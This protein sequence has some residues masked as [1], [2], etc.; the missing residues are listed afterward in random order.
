MN[1]VRGQGVWLYDENGLGYLDAINNVTHVGHSNPRVIEALTRQARRLNTN[2]R[3][4][5]DGFAR[6]AQR[7]VATLPDHLEV[8]FLV[9]TGSE[10]NDLALRIAR[11]VTGREDVMVIDGAYHGNTTA[12]TNISP[13]RY[14]GPGG[15]GAPPTTHEVMRPDRYRGPYGY[16]CADAGARYADDVRATA[17]R[18]VAQGRP[19]AAL[20]AE[21]LQ[22]TAGTTVFPDG[23]LAAAFAYAKQVGALCISDEVQVGFGRTGD[24]FW[25]FEAQGAVPDIV[26]MGKPIGNGH[27][28]AAVVTTREIA[29]TF[30]TGMKYFNTFGGN[31]VS[32]EVGLAVLDEIESLGLQRRAAEVG[33]YFLTSL[34][35][36]MDR[37]P[38]I[39]DVRGRGLYLGV[40]LVRDRATLEPATHEAYLIAERMKDEGVIVY[41]TG[42][43]DNVLKLK[44]PMVFDRSHADLFV[45]TLDAVLTNRW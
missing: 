9:C 7:L 10:A 19:P 13:N 17:Q 34:Q 41:P 44:P 36:L 16:D 40:E 12:V 38:L 8:V 29:A 6:F 18:L 2:S 14:Q 23:Y 15:A 27:P 30:D 26:T 20:I 24:S 33:A 37:H 42:G 35:G 31:P 4:V 11:Q 45:D 1:L 43:Y 39:G 28:L 21:S 32:C 22:G 5:Y 25:C 3:F